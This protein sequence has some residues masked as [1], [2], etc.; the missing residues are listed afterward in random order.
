[1]RIFVL[2]TGRCGTVTFS[3][4]CGHIT[5]Y[6]SG[7]E[8]NMGRIANFNYPDNHI[9]VDGHL[10]WILP[11]LLDAHPDAKFVHL[12]RDKAETCRSLA[13]RES[14]DLYAELCFMA[15]RTPDRAANVLYDN[16]NRLI[17]LLCP[18]ALRL[19]LETIKE[20]FWQFWELAGAEGDLEAAVGEFDY[21]YNE[22]GL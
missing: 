2:G 11:L 20:D 15:P 22:S 5:N 1:M 7:H 16:T 14:M 9:E 12:I 10:Q 21:H 13:R 8:S 17:E 3:K 6:T 18:G 19:R 4:A